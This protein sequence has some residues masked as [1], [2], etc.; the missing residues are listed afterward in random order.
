MTSYCYDFL[1]EASS[2]IYKPMF[3]NRA[4]MP[5]VATF[6]TLPAPYIAIFVP[7]IYYRLFLGLRK[8]PQTQP[9][10]AFS[11][12]MGV[13]LGQYG[14]F[15]RSMGVFSGLT[16]VFLGRMGAFSGLKGG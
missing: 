3:L 12:R 6:H 8:R 10:G 5:I 7:Y 14:R 2:N 11:G 16:G 15:L 1:A 4:T 9:P 13:F